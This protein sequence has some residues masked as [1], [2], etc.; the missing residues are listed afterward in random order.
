MPVKINKPLVV[1]RKIAAQV[2]MRGMKPIARNMISQL[3]VSSK[4]FTNAVKGRNIDWSTAHT[5]AKFI[6]VNAEDIASEAN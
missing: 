3:G 6:G 2:E 4:T 1:R 5:I